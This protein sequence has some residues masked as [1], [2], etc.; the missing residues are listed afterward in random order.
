MSSL[1]SLR[2]SREIEDAILSGQFK[3]RERLVE[4]DLI[5]RFG[6]SRTVIREALKRLEAKGLIRTAPYRGA[7]VAD[8]T[9][10]EIEEIYFLRA[11]L[12]KIAARLVLKHITPAEIQQ[13]K[14]LSKEVERHLRSKTHQMIEVD[15]EF[16]R[17]MFKVCRNS[18]LYDM[19]DYLRTKAHIVRYNA[20]SLPHRIEQSILEHRE[21]IR[22]IEDRNLSQFERLILRHLTFSKNSYLSQVKGLPLK[23]QGGLKD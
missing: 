4:M 16:H 12:E 22:A 3:P 19:I 14:K 1:N 15:S 18:Y 9:V 20:W 11:E 8:L 5:E 17:T 6:V 23:S 21:M 13:L 7:V 10:E 2:I